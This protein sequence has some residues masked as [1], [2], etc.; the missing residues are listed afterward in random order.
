MSKC[1][2]EKPITIEYLPSRIDIQRC[3]IFLRQPKQRNPVTVECRFTFWIVEGAVVKY[4]FGFQKQAASRRKTH[5][6]G[7]AII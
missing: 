3:A 5:D 7:L 4:G 6:Y 1:I 2:A